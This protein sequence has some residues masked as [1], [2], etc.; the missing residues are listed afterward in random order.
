MV[1][2]DSVETHYTLTS[3]KVIIF[4]LKS[5]SQKWLLLDQERCKPDRLEASQER[6]KWRANIPAACCVVMCVMCTE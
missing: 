3:L 5:Y 6:P 1:S 2:D 4:Q